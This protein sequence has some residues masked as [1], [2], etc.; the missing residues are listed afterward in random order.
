MLGDVVAN[1]TR[2]HDL[3]EIATI[4][5]DPHKTNAMLAWYRQGN[6]LW[7]ID[8][9]TDP[10]PQ[11]ATLLSARDVDDTGGDTEFASTY[12]AYDSLD[13]AEQYRIAQL[14]VLHSFAA[15]QERAHPDATADERARWD[16]VPT[17]VH[18]LVWNRRDGRRSLLLGGDRR[19]SRRLADPRRAGVARPPPPLGDPTRV[20]RHVTTGDEATSS[21][22][23]TP[24][25]FTGPY[26]SS[27]RRRA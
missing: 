1:P 24:G 17:Q 20:R 27:R 9:A 15:A 6:F 8:G 22:G 18:P 4:T 7:H 19:A 2:E 13:V 11:R 10:L 25:C 3:L 23:T 5:L 14:Q 16:R 21:S 12:L 26:R